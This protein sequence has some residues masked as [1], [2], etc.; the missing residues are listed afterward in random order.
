MKKNLDLIVMCD[1]LKYV[2]KPHGAVKNIFAF[3]HENPIKTY[4]KPF[5]VGA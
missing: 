1:S 3:V 4:A 5:C 2:S